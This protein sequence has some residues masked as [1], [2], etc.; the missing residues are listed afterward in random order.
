[1]LLIYVNLWTYRVSTHAPI[2]QAWGPMVERGLG[3]A[4]E[5]EGVICWA[6]VASSPCTV[7]AAN[8]P[9]RIRIRSSHCTRYEMGLSDGNTIKEQMTPV[10]AF[11]LLME[12]MGHFR[13]EWLIHRNNRRNRM[14]I[15]PS[16]SIPG[17]SSFQ[18]NGNESSRHYRTSRVGMSVTYWYN[19]IHDVMENANCGRKE[20]LSCSA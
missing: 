14:G 19:R 5:V 17:T 9:I 2:F 8:D 11:I 20:T 6:P 15:K 18:W 4:Q 12:K 13:G 1:M 16:T 7:D 10:A 3:G